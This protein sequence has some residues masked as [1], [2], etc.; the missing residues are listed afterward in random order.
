MAWPR[1]TRSRKTGRSCSVVSRAASRLSS[2]LRESAGD[3][4]V[5]LLAECDAASRAG[6]P[7]QIAESVDPAD[8][9]AE[10]LGP[11]GGGEIGTN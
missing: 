4:C 8:M 9:G 5:E 2:M 11:E 10:G 6:S 1:L 3:D 7:V